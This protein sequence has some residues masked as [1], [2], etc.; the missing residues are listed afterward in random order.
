M[1]CCSAA[2]A[3]A[4]AFGFVTL[5]LAVMMY[6]GDVPHISVQGVKATETLL[7]ATAGSGRDLLSSRAPG[8]RHGASLLPAR[9][10][11]S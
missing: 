7:S 6:C 1:L 4:L 5:V 2:Q 11:V 8:W 10:A 9:L 3:F